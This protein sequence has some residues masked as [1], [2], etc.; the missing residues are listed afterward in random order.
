[1]D[2]SYLI[3][4]FVILPLGGA[5][6]IPTLG[7]LIPGMHRYLTSLLMLFLAILSVFLMMQG[8]PSAV[9][10]I[11]GWEPVNNIPI[12]IYLILD[13]LSGFLLLIINILGFFSA[14]YAISYIRRFTNEHLFYTLMCLMIAGMNGVVL[15][16]DLFNLYVFLEISVISSYALVA[17]GVERS[18][19]EASF[20][21]QVLG[22]LASLLI[23]LGIALLYWNTGTLNLAD[24]ASVLAGQ[25]EG[26]YLVF[27]QMLFVVGL[28]IKAALIPF[29]AWLPD[30]HSS[31]PSPIS[32]MLS[33]VLIKAVGLYTLIRLLFNVFPLNQ[34]VALV[35][36]VIGSLSMIIGVLLAIGQ[37]DLKRLLAYHS[38][39][40]MGY[41]VIGIGIGMMILVQGGD[42]LV[43]GLAIA[44]GLF[45]MINHAVFKGL[46]F[47]NAGAIE[48]AIGTRDLMK[49]GGLA[50][51]MPFTYGA[52]FCASMAISGLPP[53]NGFFSKLI[54]ILAALKGGFILLAILAVIGSI[55][56]LASFMKF[57]RY[58]FHNQT[59]AHPEAREVPFPMV[60]T[61]LS[62]ALLCLVLSLLIFPGIRELFLGP[63]TE[64]LIHPASYS[65][66]LLTP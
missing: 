3:T 11:G 48:Y 58:A 44:G 30:A 14:F 46:L 61:M 53:F 26:I 41:V 39:S 16:G 60:F 9:Y 8:N 35:I 49:M 25:E 40:Q 38:I 52:S 20:K 43:A 63:A 24:I 37:W 4:L 62:L 23:L 7:R 10:K 33:G 64:I 5:F 50:K 65:L 54:I 6:L 47:L 57:Q 22:G 45:H 59:E 36:T 34:E 32:A 66:K 31:A 19:L 12:G 29:H 27:V 13:G 2:A 51:K 28:S 55:V 56:T 15:S 42:T 1:M 18:E 21:Y 17:Y